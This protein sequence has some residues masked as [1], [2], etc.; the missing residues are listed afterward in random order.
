[1]WNNTNGS[2][3]DATL[4][5]GQ[6]LG[7]YE[8]LLPIASGGMGNVWA[9]RLKGT[10]GFR[11]IVAIKTILHTGEDAKLEQMLLQEATIASQVHHPNVVETLELGEHQGLMFLVMELVEGE[12]LSCLMREAQTT[13]GVP[14]KVAVNL[15]GQ[16][17]R[18]L[19]AAHDL[20]DADGA[21]MGLVHRD[22]SPPNLI[23]TYSGT[24]KIVDFGV[25]TTSSSAT[26]GSGEIK[27]K[28]S[29]LAPEQLRGDSLD[30]RVDVFATGIV[31]Y[32]LTVGRHPFKAPTEAKTISR[33]MSDSRPTPPSA[34]GPA[35]PEAL[36]YVVLRAL[37]KDPTNR[38]QSAA[39][40]LSALHRAMPEAFDPS[41]ERVTTEYV[42][43]LL[44]NKMVQRRATLRM[45]EED[46][47]R[48][49]R[50]S[51]SSLP[52][53]VATG[54]PPIPKVPSRVIYAAGG[55]VLAFVL[56][57]GV[58]A[59]TGFE[60]LVGEDVAEKEVAARELP[61]V[62]T[63]EGPDDHLGGPKREVA[64][65]SR[66]AA[67]AVQEATSGSVFRS[68]PAR[69]KAGV[70]AKE[71]TPKKGAIQAL[72]PTD[73]S[74]DQPESLDP[75]ARVDSGLAWNGAMPEPE[76]PM[77]L[78][79]EAAPTPSA[80]QASFVA[81]VIVPQAAPAA[82]PPGIRMLS[83]KLAHRKLTID[84]S[85][86]AYRVKLPP[87]LE[88]SKSSFAATVRIC[89]SPEGKVTSVEV[90]RPGGPA[91]DAQLPEVLSR[92]RYSPLVE[93]GVKIPFC[94]ALRYEL[95]AR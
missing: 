12:S 46:T 66:T 71:G 59:L 58:R 21:P 88:G 13:G 48:T 8:L 52:V 76:E 42:G 53:M 4:S 36:E 86:D 5:P 24:V 51:A 67:A 57:L 26:Q 29:Y 56:A 64:L 65:P 18:G 3:N 6:M 62:A 55:M 33:I 54:A 61:A 41:A 23:V 30:Q 69:G 75:V 79:Y 47:E 70:A 50:P 80:P 11:K 74:A 32:Q 40:F 93:N 72:A 25:A 73:A 39:E 84:P 92:W 37:E 63:Q 31:L 91:I 10:R 94:Y 77:E 38:W 34:W 15:I 28:I 20:S 19:S 44:R 78:P 83:S 17:C 82:R 81:A 1:M 90:T 95:A 68:R 35:Y 87:A 89:V 22:I 60:P 2:I 27:G 7:R 85:S 45:A 9:A 49:S 43:G 14:L 16:V